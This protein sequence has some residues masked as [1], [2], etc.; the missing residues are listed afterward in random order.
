MNKEHEGEKRVS[1]SDNESESQMNT[2]MNS[3]SSLSKGEDPGWTQT[4]DNI[5][6]KFPKLTD[7]DIK[8]LDGNLDELSSKLQDAYG[9]SSEDANLKVRELKSLSSHPQGGLRR[10]GVDR[11]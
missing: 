11:V 4:R 7:E 5:R 6:S 2:N 8:E 10:E 9:Y 1:G 3:E